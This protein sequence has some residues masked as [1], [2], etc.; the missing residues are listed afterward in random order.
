ME[1]LT[2]DHEMWDEIDEGDRYD[3]DPDYVEANPNETVPQV[4]CLGCEEPC[5]LPI[6]CHC[7]GDLC[8]NCSCG[9]CEVDLFCPAQSNS[10]YD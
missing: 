3:D 9:N 5:R 2:E 1:L 8:E 7:G 6:V 4:E 10:L